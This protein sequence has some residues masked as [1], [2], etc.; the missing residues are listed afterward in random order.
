MNKI[1]NLYV[2][3]INDE[4]VKIEEEKINILLNLIRYHTHNTNTSNR[5]LREYRVKCER[6]KI[7]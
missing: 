3:N 2:K 4:I 5:L 1:K 6:L 7:I